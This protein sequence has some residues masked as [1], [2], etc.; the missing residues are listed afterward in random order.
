LI[1]AFEDSEIETAFTGCW[2]AVKDLTALH[3]KL[4]SCRNK[5]AFKNSKVAC[6]D[7]IQA[8]YDYKL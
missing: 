5:A 1:E 7:F 4:H 6:T 8:P 3:I 2:S